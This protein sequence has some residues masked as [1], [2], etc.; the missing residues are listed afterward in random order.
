MGDPIAVLA[1]RKKRDQIAATIAHYERLTRE[2]EHDLAHVNAALRL[3]EVTGEA[4][5]LPP[6]VDLNR[7]LK[8]G[9][10]TKICMDALAAEGPLDTRQ[11]ALRIIRAKGLTESDKVL[12]QSIALRVVQT[13]RMRARR[14]KVECITKTKGVCVWRLPTGP[15]RPTELPLGTS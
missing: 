5:D 8:R 7:L 15:W 1:L 3:F 10:T 14:N 13:L 6:Y 12:A 11:L 2:A 9:E 4:A